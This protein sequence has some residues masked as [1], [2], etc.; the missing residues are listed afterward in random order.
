MLALFLMIFLERQCLTQK[1]FIFPMVEKDSH[2]FIS[3]KIGNEKQQNVSFAINNNI[4]QSTICKSI[5]DNGE[6]PKV[7]LSQVNLPS[8]SYKH[9][10]NGQLIETFIS[11]DYLTITS[12]FIMV[13]NSN[14]VSELS[15]I[16]STTISD[17][18]THD[19]VINYL[20]YQNFISFQVFTVDLISNELEIGEDNSIHYNSHCSLLNYTFIKA[21]GQNLKI[22]FSSFDI[23]VGK[24]GK[25]HSF[26]FSE[27]AVI[28]FSKRFIL[29]PYEL[30][31]QLFNKFFFVTSYEELPCYYSVKDQS[32]DVEVLCSLNIFENSKYKNLINEASLT[33]GNEI[34]VHVDK[35]HMFIK[36]SQGYKL[37]FEFSQEVNEWVFGYEV[38]KGYALKFDYESCSVGFAT[39][40]VVVNFKKEIIKIIIIVLVILMSFFITKMS[41]IK[42]KIINEKN[43]K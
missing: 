17:K 3:V 41:F 34:T 43:K 9:E 32:Y 25:S 42:I 4:I 21:S 7:I 20:F 19:S 37:I 39:E 35:E 28:D 36:E 11:F 2:L 6:T 38:F 18:I 23:I 14:C 24:T 30:R 5:F 31:Y 1:A 40:T 8:L 33:F 26:P 15:L 13:N 10:Y 22:P 12:S 16:F 27:F 29:V